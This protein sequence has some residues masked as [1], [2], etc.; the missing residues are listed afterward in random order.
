MPALSLPAPLAALRAGFGRHRRAI[1]WA[2]NAAVLGYV[3]WQVW[4]LGLGAVL[5]ALPTN[6]FFYLI[7]LLHFAATPAAERQIFA[8]MW[9]AERR[10]PWRVLLRKRTMNAVLISYSGDLWFYLWAR[11]RT[12]LSDRQILSSVKDST[13]LS[14]IAAGAGTL[15]MAVWAIA[16]G[17]GETIRLAIG[18]HVRGVIIAALVALFVLPIV[19]RLRSAIFALTTRLIWLVL[20]LHVLRLVATQVLQAWQWAVAM[21]EVPFALWLLLLTVQLIVLQIPLV[22]NADLIFL[23]V[24]VRLTGELGVDRAQLTAL[25][26]ATSV[27]KQVVNLA[28]LAITSLI[29]P[30]Q[31][32]DT[33][34]AVSEGEGPDERRA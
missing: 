1:G 25:L 19:F 15:L 13:I 12:A 22:P 27:F 8:L 28:T 34:A 31:P 18:D 7:Y 20:G 29:T 21:P 11:A 16:T 24:S 23:A 4:Q 5:G 3:G 9:P 32:V 14:G 2:V 17:G 10:I 30:A 33:R 6:P 26:L